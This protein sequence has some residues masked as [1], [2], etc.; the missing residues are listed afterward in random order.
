MEEVEPWDDDDDDC[1][2]DMLTIRMEEVEPWYD[3][4]DDDVDDNEG[5]DGRRWEGAS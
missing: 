5:E 1:D 2:D 4:D 3:D